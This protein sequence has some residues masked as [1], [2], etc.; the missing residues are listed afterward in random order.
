MKVIRYQDKNGIIGHAAQQEDGSALKLSGDIYHSPQVTLEKADVAKLLAPVVPSSIICIGLN[1]RHHA[2]ET[3][4][5]FPEQPVVFS[6][7]S[8]RC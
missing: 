7:A 2:D 6:R 3:G 8:T 4:A 1:Y 5:K